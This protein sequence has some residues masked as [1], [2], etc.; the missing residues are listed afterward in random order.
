MVKQE[1]A[2]KRIVRASKRMGR[3]FQDNLI[4]DLQYVPDLV[5][6]GSFFKRWVA[7][8]RWARIDVA[9]INEVARPQV[10]ARTHARVA[11][12]AGAAG[13]IL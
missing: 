9:G 6:C 1:S 12:R 8:A 3:F 5:A 13:R 7:C 10:C 2:L 11:A 4:I